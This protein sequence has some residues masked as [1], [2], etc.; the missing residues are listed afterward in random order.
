[1]VVLLKKCFSHQT[2]AGIAAGTKN[3]YLHN[4]TIQ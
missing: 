4:S 2:S 3:K 1:L